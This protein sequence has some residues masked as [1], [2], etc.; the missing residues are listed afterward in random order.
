MNIFHRDTCRLCEGRSLDLVLPLTPTPLADAY[1][2]SKD[3]AQEI[4]P[5]DL[6]LCRDCGHVQLLDVVQAGVI[7]R[8]YIYET[9]SSLGLVDHFRTYAQEVVEQFKV[10]KDSF[11]VDIGSNDGSLLQCFQEHGMRVLGIDPA[12]AI[13]QNATAAGVETWPEFFD[14]ELARKIKQTKGAA[15]VITSNNLV[16]NVDD[17]D[18]FFDAIRE[19][20]APEGVF[21]F[22]S[23]YLLDFINNMVFDFAY[24][25]HLSY[26]SVTPLL[27]FCRK[28]GLR[29]IDAKHIPTK[30]GSLR[31][32]IQHDAAKQPSSPNLSDIVKK[33]ETVGTRRPETFHAFKSRIDKAKTDLLTELKGL[34]AKGKTIAG[35]GASATTTTL[36]YHFDLCELLSFIADDYPA[37]QDLFSPG[38][39]IP[40]LPSSALYDRRPDYVV[41]IAWRYWK[42]IVEKH[43]RFLDEGGHFLVPLPTLQT[44]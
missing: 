27:G 26:F 11:V 14:L 17:L 4:Y 6:Y 29:M 40:I 32:M 18:S 16:A 5:L 31:Y 30:G 12:V 42:P 21:L 38:Y 10:P 24:H 33:E 15:T 2:P 8:D 28:H 41:I 3:V 23:F 43:R 25:E 20:L 39:H 34:I 13:A 7:Y 19:L 44:I 22:E 9:K 36:I 1:V 35:Y 37:K